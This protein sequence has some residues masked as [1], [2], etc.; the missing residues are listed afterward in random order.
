V[1]AWQM[2]AEG[3]YSKI[4]NDAPEVDSQALFLSRATLKKKAL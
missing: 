1:K 4:S 3:I 2:N